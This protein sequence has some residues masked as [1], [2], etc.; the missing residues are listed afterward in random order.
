ML[1]G[2]A[3]VGKPEVV[4]KLVDEQIDQSGVNYFSSRFLFGDISYSE[5][6][7]AIDAFS[8]MFFPR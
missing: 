8:E 5:A 3:I 4:K 7:Y 6:I 2:L 1:S